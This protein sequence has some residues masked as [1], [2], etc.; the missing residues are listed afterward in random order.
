MFITE[1]WLHPDI[2]NGLIDPKA[3]FVVLRK[4]RDGSRGGG[5]CI[6]IKKCFT[7]IPVI[8]AKKY[9]NLEILAFDFA[10]IN[11]NLRIFVVYRP[12][13]NDNLGACYVSSLIECLNDLVSN[14][15]VHVS[16]ADFN[17]PRIDWNNV[18]CPDDKINKPVLN[19]VVESGLRQLINFPTRNDNLL[20]ILLT[21]DDQLI[22][23]VASYPPFGH[24]DHCV[25]QF[26]ISLM[27]DWQPN[28]VHDSDSVTRYNWMQADYD[29]MHIY[30]SCVDWLSMV[31][32]NPCAQSLWSAFI[33]ELRVAIDLFVPVHTKSHRSNSGIGHQK[34]R[35][36]HCREIRKCESKKR[37]LWKKLRSHPH[38]SLLRGKYRDCVFRWHEL[39]RNDEVVVE[40]R[41]VSSNDLGAFYRHVNRRIGHRSNIGAIVDE[42]NDIV[43]DDTGK[44]NVFNKFFSSVGVTD[45][46]IVPQCVNVVS[47]ETLDEIVI[48]ELDVLRA[49]NKL[50]CKLTCGPDNL[51]PVLFKRLKHCLSKPLALIFNQ[52][53]SVGVVPS[54]WKQAIIVPVFKKGAAGMVSNYRPISLT[55]VLSKI[56]ERIISNKIMEFLIS[57]KALHAAQHG[58]VNGRS[59]CTNLLESM[60]DWTIYLQARDQTAII[61]I[62]FSKAFDTVSHNKLFSRLQAYGLGGT[63]LLWLQSFFS[64]R[65]HRTRVGQ[66]LSDI[67]DLVSGV[68]QG[69]VIGPLMF[70]IF[71]DELIRILEKHGIKVKL[72]A[73]DV[74]LYLRIV[75][76]VDVVKLQAALDELISWA[77]TW[78]LSVSIDKCC[79]LNVGK[80]A[81]DT[82]FCIKGQVLPI[83][84][85]CRDLGVIMSDDL[86]PSAHIGSVV[87]KAHQRANAI[88]RSFVSRDISLLIR[89]YLVY[90]RPIVEYN[91]VIWSPYLK[92]DIEAIERVQRR[93]T[94]RLP[95]FNQLSYSER[96]SHLQ[97]P[98][99]ELR[100][101]HCDLT[102]CYK[103]LFGYVD[104][105][106]D[107]FFELS[108]C[109][110]TRGHHYKLFKKY[111]DIRV[112][113]A[114]FS[115]RVVNVWNSLPP[116]TVDFTSLVTFNRTISHV[117]FSAFLT[118]FS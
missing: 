20:D 7:I 71:I 5:V 118:V 67:A 43:A 28:D 88:L 36:R 90:V 8:F 95:G 81:F 38:D 52:L 6:L 61:Y 94:K 41:I 70:L 40:E 3:E 59:T 15:R 97:L 104:M 45:N 103:I 63:I 105:Q 54:E 12:P 80:T 86:S 92:Q 74:K 37:L 68:I 53:L 34:R 39:T 69:S 48:D 101:L 113:S 10:N 64:G 106:A 87:A 82:R 55:C 57:H 114:F 99:L 47:C 35:H 27:F 83:V 100:R 19:F 109:L 72:Y 42:N 23:S 115:E 51:P 46:N 29:S 13:Q 22:R 96:L 14:R 102:W 11:P 58:F 110:Q 112:R 89:A 24:S 50:K 75:N 66:F 31:C 2:S 107:K 111:S 108:P 1:S 78:Q 44:A 25:I 16:V 84:T 85:S 60:N 93:F 56:M 73:D 33:K 98:T 21:D 9:A 91:S 76:D 26:F 77:D 17:L 116:N 49:I 4:D 79:V 30:L 65:T 62:D 32:L 117:D 18:C